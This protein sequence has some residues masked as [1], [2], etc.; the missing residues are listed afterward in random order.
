MKRFDRIFSLSSMLFL[1][2]EKKKITL[3]KGRE[4]DF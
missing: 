4:R 2:L 3:A 1:F